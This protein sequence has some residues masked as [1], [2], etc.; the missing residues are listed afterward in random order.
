VVDGV[1]AIP[2]QVHNE[3]VD[4]SRVVAMAVVKKGIICPI[5]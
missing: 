3:E 5:A 4:V 1:E 2:F